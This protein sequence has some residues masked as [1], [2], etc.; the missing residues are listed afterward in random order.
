MLLEDKNASKAIR[1]AWSG[2]KCKFDDLS[3]FERFAF[4]CENPD[5]FV[6]NRFPE[7]LESAIYC[8]T[9]ERAL[10]TSGEGLDREITK[11]LWCR[12]FAPDLIEGAHFKAFKKS[13]S[14][15]LA[16]E[17]ALEKAALLLYERASENS[18]HELRIAELFED[19]GYGEKGLP[20]CCSE[21][22][23]ALL[24]QY[25]NSDA[26]YLAIDFAERK[27][28]RP[29]AY[30][31]EI[32]YKKALC[33]ENYKNVTSDEI[34]TLCVW[35]A[36][37]VMLKSDAHPRI[38]VSDAE[39]IKIFID[40]LSRLRIERPITVCIDY[41]RA[42]SRFISEFSEIASHSPERVSLA[43]V[44]AAATNR[45]DFAKRAMTVLQTLPLGAFER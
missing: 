26:T 10:L 45:E 19:V 21:A 16:C 36:C 39:Q 44:C 29:D 41:R 43:L 20:G 5:L 28:T 9:G 24:S 34:L 3:D 38:Y 31:A 17:Q 2:E 7:M 1:L 40:L 25:I 12:I 8:D 33:D 35:L 18:K 4:V 42:D 11:K 37:R 32:I 30:S 27:Y 22:A 6:G 14:E 13:Y 23:E 15:R